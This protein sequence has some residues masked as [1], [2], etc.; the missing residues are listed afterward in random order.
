MTFWTHE[1]VRV[2]AGGKWLAPPPERVER[3]PGGVSIDTRTLH[4]GQVFVA[5]A[6][7]RVDGH[8]YL[9]AA[10]EAGASMALVE[11]AVAALP[12]GLPV[13][14]VRDGREAL[15]RLAKAYRDATPNL[16]VVGVTGSNG[17][18]TTVRLIDA[19]LGGSL[20]GSASE[21]S[22]NN[23]LG[24]PLTLLN[25]GPAD[26]YVVCEMGMSTPG[27]IAALGRI[28]RPDVAVITSVGRAH[29]QGLGSVE[30]IAAEKASILEHLRVGGVGVIPAG[31]EPLERAVARLEAV[32]GAPARLVRVGVGDGADL[33]VGDVKAGARGVLFS[34]NERAGFSVPLLGTHNAHN[35]ALAVAVGRRFGL[36]DDAIRDGLAGVRATAGRLERV[37]VSG[38][39]GSVAVL[40]DAYNA[41]PDSVLAALRTLG[42]MKP[43]KGGR[44]V[45]ILGDMLELGDSSESAHAE[46]ARAIAGSRGIHAAVLVGPAMSAAAGEAGAK[47][48]AADL[49]GE[50]DADRIAAMVEAGDVVLIKAS[51]GGRLERVA[52]AIER[53]FG[54]AG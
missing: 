43:T 28:A 50:A 29:L 18:T 22:Y 14:L 25:A 26:Q 42:E 51:R 33:R 46:V 17:K 45:A 4:A 47:A 11:R 6:G 20:R 7:E 21:R 54:G 40:N 44:R 32:A 2:A 36:D 13:V 34:I 24:L 39:A 31:V 27:E 35:A 3:H 41:N 48:T 8:A 1:A 52:D 30:A 12:E 53:R 23:A 10:C 37:K 5:L 9:A 38:A 49:A 19:V 16:R 15:T